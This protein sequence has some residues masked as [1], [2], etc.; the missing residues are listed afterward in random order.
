MTAQQAIERL[1]QAGYTVKGAE[2][3]WWRLRWP[4][5][6][7]GVVGGET[8]MNERG[9]IAEAMIATGHGEQPEPKFGDAPEVEEIARVLIPRH[10]SHLVE[11]KI[12]YLWR[13]GKWESQGQTTL[14]KC[15]RLSA[16]DEFLTGH[17]FLIMINWPAWQASTP[18]QR[19]ALVDHELSHAG[20]DED[21]DGNPRWV[22]VPHDVEEFA[23][24]IERHGLWKPDVERFGKVA[25]RKVNQL[26][27]DVDAFR[28]EV[29]DPEDMIA[30][31]GE[32][33]AAL[34]DTKI[35]FSSGGRSVTTTGD[36]LRRAADELAR[37][38][39]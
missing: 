13:Y 35:T 25:A 36:G 28:R 7:D 20:M 14:G 4:Q 10:H 5:D 8:M 30:A 23:A 1:Q 31:A 26:E 39:G 19:T 6:A 32:D 2:P 29:E 11:A 38:R 33:D 17:N 18:E 22:T 3:G 24:I 21:K 34:D 27:F 9:L 12:R 16:R 15:Y 37:R